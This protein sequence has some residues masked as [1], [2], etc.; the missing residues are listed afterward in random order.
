MYHNF[1]E[2]S[3]LF[4]SFTFLNIIKSKASKEEKYF[5]CEFAADSGPEM[6]KDVCDMLLCDRIDFTEDHRVTHCAWD[7]VWVQF[8][9]RWSCQSPRSSRE[10]P[11]H[12]WLW[13]SHLSPK[14]T[15]AFKRDVV[16]I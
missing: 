13:P 16:V 11:W 7:R 5:K 2:T 4:H 3:G 9:L 12:A 6:W 10:G 15:C 1:S 8:L 14:L